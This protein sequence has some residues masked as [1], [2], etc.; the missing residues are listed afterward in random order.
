MVSLVILFFMTVFGPKQTD[1]KTF[2][3][4]I[5]PGELH[6]LSEGFALCSWG[7]VTSPG[8]KADFGG[9][10]DNVKLCVTINVSYK[11]AT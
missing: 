5:S 2:M 11:F 4:G 9:V 3:N 8:L 1:P 10:V 6:N 7:S